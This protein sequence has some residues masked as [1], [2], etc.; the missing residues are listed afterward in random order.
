MN[1][2]TLCSVTRSGSDTG[3]GGSLL[4]LKTGLEKR[5]VMVE[6]Y[7]P[8]LKAN[9]V[10]SDF[11]YGLSGIKRNNAVHSYTELCWNTRG[12]FRTFCGVWK[13]NQRIYLEEKAYA[14]KSQLF[15]QPFF[16]FHRRLEEKSIE[17]NV[18]ICESDSIRS[19]L[20]RE[21]GVELNNIIKIPI[22]MDSK[23]L[24]FEKGNR[25]KFGLNDDDFIV[26]CVGTLE[27]NKGLKYLLE[28][29]RILK[30]EKIKFILRS[31]PIYN[32]HPLWSDYLDVK[33]S[34]LFLPKFQDMR[35]FY[36]LSDCYFMPSTYEAFNIALTEAMACEKPA[37]AFED[38]GIANEAVFDNNTGF[39]VKFRDCGAA[40][41]KILHLYNNPGKCKKMGEKARALVKER[42]TLDQMIDGHLKAYGFS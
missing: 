27:Y 32:N 42:F 38:V 39:K 10:F 33:G 2:L 22:G 40:A 17:N 20:H 24:F 29:A 31:K 7:Y 11:Y 35:D 8:K 19:E 5:G 28:T 34:V 18:L 4:K 36:N 6:E 9:M 15:F 26:S 25:N 21:Y 12:A 30:G 14:E 3:V 23:Q 41:E 16:F 1:K 37:V 13:A